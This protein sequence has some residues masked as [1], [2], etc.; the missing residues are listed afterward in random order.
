MDDNILP[1][2]IPRCAV[3]VD[4]QKCLP[5]QVARGRREKQDVVRA[6][7][8][9]CRSKISIKIACRKYSGRDCRIDSIHRKAQLKTRG[10]EVYP[11][12]V[13]VRRAR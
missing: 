5:L 13:V 12:D 10:I 2:L 9:Q 3:G 8:G 7:T 11:D 4:D 1:G 6:Q